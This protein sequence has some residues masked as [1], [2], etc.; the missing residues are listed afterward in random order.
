MIFSL[1]AALFGILVKQWIREYMKW[2]SA[3][4]HPRDNVLVR[5]IRFEAWNDWNVPTTIAAVPALLEIALVFFVCGLVILLWTLDPVV[6]IVIT[7]AAAVFLSIAATFTFLP[8]FFRRCP[9]KSPTAWAFAVLWDFHTRYIPHKFCSLQKPAGYWFWRR[10]RMG[11]WVQQ[12]GERLMKTSGLD[13]DHPRIGDWTAFAHDWRSRDL[14]N[15]WSSLWPGTKR[16]DAISLLEELR[17]ERTGP[18]TDFRVPSLYWDSLPTL[19]HNAQRTI[20]ELSPLVRALAWVSQASQD[21]R[22]QAHVLSCVESLETRFTLPHDLSTESFTSRFFDK[23]GVRAVSYWHLALDLL[24]QSA[25]STG[26]KPV[27]EERMNVGTLT[28]EVKVAESIFEYMRMEVGWEVSLNGDSSEVLAFS[29]LLAHSVRTLSRILSSP[30]VS[31]HA[32]N[33][34]RPRNVLRLRQYLAVLRYLWLR[35]NCS[36]PD[37]GDHLYD[38][39]VETVDQD[40]RSQMLLFPDWQ[41][42]M[43]YI[44]YVHDSPKL[45]KLM[46]ELGEFSAT[47]AIV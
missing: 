24:R 36:T 3:L 39:F 20:T 15:L 19:L 16:G 9:Y 11:G 44:I 2:N 47:L 25:R 7:T 18:P 22:T 23:D 26:K 27:A 8:A 14:A 37:V 29:H 34:L 5:Q 10:G 30:L 31:F 38:T 28:A 40:S 45:K 43:L 21:A 4:A 42:T 6:S 35:C 13:D 33:R 12:F 32:F 46:D 41:P 1:A 17:L